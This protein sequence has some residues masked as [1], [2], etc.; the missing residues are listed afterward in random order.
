MSAPDEAEVQ[1][2]DRE[3]P[4]GEGLLKMERS[5]TGRKNCQHRRLSDHGQ[6][7]LTRI[8]QVLSL[9]DERAVFQALT[10]KQTLA[11]LDHPLAAK[12]V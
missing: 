10:L 3:R 12:L 7:L 6:E 2:L 4:A 11:R 8:Q 9:R 1:V 5:R